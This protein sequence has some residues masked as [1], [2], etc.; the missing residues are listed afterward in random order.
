[1]KCS[2]FVA[3]VFVTMTTAAHAQTGMDLHRQCGNAL[4]A[5]FLN[6]N[7]CHGYISG[8]VNGLV[9]SGNHTV[10]LS[11]GVTDT[12]AVMIVQNYMRAHPEQLNDS[13]DT[14]IQRSMTESFPCPSILS[15]FTTR[16]SPSQTAGETPWWF[17]G[18]IE[19]FLVAFVIALMVAALAGAV[20]LAKAPVRA[21]RR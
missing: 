10:C 7:Y 17:A 14:I 6:R 19:V 4:T 16:Q 1:M 15:P 3:A 11:R 21:A 2:I 9:A 8:I 13:G 12:Q 20:A 18:G 5:G